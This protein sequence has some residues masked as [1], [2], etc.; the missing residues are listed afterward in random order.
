MKTAI[1]AELPEQLVANARA[2]VEEGW[3]DDFNDLLAE[4]LRRCLES[5]S[6]HPV[7]SFIQEDV[8]WGL[9]G[10]EWACAANNRATG[11][12]V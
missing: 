3:V 5:H 8:V 4:A 6:S 1:Q 12:A 10:R 11:D 7:E 2:F 9:R